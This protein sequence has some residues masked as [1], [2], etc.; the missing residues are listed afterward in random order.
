M[1]RLALVT[2]ALL[3]ALPILRQ[4]ISSALVTRGDALLYLRDSAAKEKY[5]LALTIDSANSSAAE[6]LVFAEFLSHD[7]RELEDGVRVASFA[8]I[9][10][11]RDA[12]L[13]MDRALCLQLLKRYVQARVDFE[14]AGKQRGDVQALTLAAADARRTHDLIGA[15][16]LL[17]LAQRTDPAYLPVRTALSRVQR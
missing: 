9:A 17:L 16:R 11:P 15:R 7:A 12:G 3:L 2:I 4:S 8:L 6:R 10:D 5:R 1:R 13:R 14:V